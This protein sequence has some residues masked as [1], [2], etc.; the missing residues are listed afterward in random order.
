YLFHAVEPNITNFCGVLVG[1][2]I[3]GYGNPNRVKTA[4]LY[5]FDIR[6]RDLRLAPASL[7]RWLATISLHLV[8]NVSCQLY[9]G[10]QLYSVTAHASRIRRN[11]IGVVARIKR[12]D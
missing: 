4:V 11:W 8:S 1:I 7:I 10:G 5:Q 3:P 12:A 9:L 2:L 6:G